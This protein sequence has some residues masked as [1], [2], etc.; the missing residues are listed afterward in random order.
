MNIPS[1]FKTLDRTPQTLKKFGLLL[2]TI[3]LLLG[4]LGLLLLKT[5]QTAAIASASLGVALLAFALLSPQH[6]LR[7]YQAWMLFALTLG[8]LIAH[9]LLLSIFYLL[10]TPIALAAKLT[11]QDFLNLK[12]DKTKKTYWEPRQKPEKPQNSYKKQF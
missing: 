6:L 4:L 8:F 1:D 9:F 7:P 3:A 2:G 11:H 10:T 5:H 12:W